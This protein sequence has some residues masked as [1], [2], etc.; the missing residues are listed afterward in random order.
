[1]CQGD[2]GGRCSNTG[3]IGVVGGDKKLAH[4]DIQHMFRVCEWLQRWSKYILAILE[5]ERRD[6]IERSYIRTR[7]FTFPFIWFEKT[8]NISRILLDMIAIVHVFLHRDFRLH[9]NV[10]AFHCHSL[11]Q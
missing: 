4:G 6:F 5:L 3:V 11:Y 8:E 9:V 1:M 7:I 2:G 10:D